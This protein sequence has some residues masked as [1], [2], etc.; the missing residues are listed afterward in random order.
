MTRFNLIAFTIFACLGLSSCHHKPVATVA[1]PLKVK[2]MV[3]QPSQMLMSRAYSGTV[4]ESN[5][6]SLSFSSAGTLRQIYVNEGDR[7]SAGQLIGVLDD[8]NLRHAHDIAQSALN[9]AQDAYNRMKMLHDAQALPDMQWV[10]VQNTLSQAQSAEAIAR[11]AMDDAK[12]YAPNSGYVAE[13]YVDAGMNVAPGV[14]VVK[15]VSIGDVKVNIAVPE[16]EISG[17]NTGA[18]A[19]ITVSALG[20]QPY[21]GRVTERGV[22][23]NALSRSYDVK[24][25]VPNPDARLL[26]GMICDVRLAND[27]VQ[28]AV[29]LPINTVLLDADN[30]NFIWTA[31]NGKAYKKIVS[32]EGMNDQ[33]IIVNPKDVDGDTIITEGL[34]KVS[35]G[36]RIEIIH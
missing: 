25:T 11:K 27:S 17:I 15:I 14:P 21:S 6:A 1:P 24:I 30:Q 16:N 10:E 31:R 19:Q 8:A 35:E 29:V 32:V 22:S 18:E 9:Q 4:E 20:S 28:S 26:P 36:T 7:V 34:Q 5:G 2:V 13:K 12:L 3:A 33:G 23:A